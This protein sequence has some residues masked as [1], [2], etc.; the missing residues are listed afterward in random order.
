MLG[1]RQNYLTAAV[2]NSSFS[3]FRLGLQGLSYPH[4]KR[5]LSKRWLSISALSRSVR[6]YLGHG[7]QNRWLSDSFLTTKSPSTV[8]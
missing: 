8:K 5:L 3:L 7:F 6:S 4:E 1:A 2:D